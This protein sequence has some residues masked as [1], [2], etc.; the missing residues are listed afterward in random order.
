MKLYI[1]GSVASGKSTLARKLSEVTG[2]ACTHL[3]ELMYEVDPESSWGNRRRNEAERDACFAEIL[4]QESYIIEDC[5]RRCFRRGMEEADQVI[6]LDLPLS[7]RYRRILLRWLK[8]NLGIEHCIYKPNWR[9][10]R[11]M[12]GWAKEFDPAEFSQYEDKL[13]VLK[14]D[15][16]INRFIK[17]LQA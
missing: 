14:N 1:T 11:T 6:L 5:G 3:D 4:S 15:R 13:T 17:E 16:E 12:F 2:V 8:Q 7:L 9:M 10:L